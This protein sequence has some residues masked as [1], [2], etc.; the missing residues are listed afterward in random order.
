MNEIVK[1]HPRIVPLKK[2][3][4]I[5]D[6]KDSLGYELSRRDNIPGMFRVGRQIRVNLDAY[7]EQT[8]VL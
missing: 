7:F 8:K 2:W 5:V 6:V 3:C 1:E 4:E